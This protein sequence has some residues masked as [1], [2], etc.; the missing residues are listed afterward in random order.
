MT[1]GVPSLIRVPVGDLAAA[2]RLYSTLLGTE[3]Y[4]EQPHYVGFR[5]GELEVG[6]DP[7]GHARGMTGPVSYWT[8]ADIEASM[9]E[10]TA[11]G[12]TE[13]E[14]PADVGGGKLVGSVRDADGNV[15]GLI[16]EPRV[17]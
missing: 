3:P 5:T 13:H 17:S 1:S 9:K 16:Q 14:S 8:V 4:L 11:A 7:N 12:A 15:T 2:T 10:L 6:L